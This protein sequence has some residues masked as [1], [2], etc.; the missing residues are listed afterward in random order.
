[1]SRPLHPGKEQVPIV[2]EAGW[3]SWPVWTRAENLPPPGF[4]PRTVE[5]VGSLYTD[6]A[7]PAHRGN[8]VLILKLGARSGERSAS[9]PGLFIL[10]ENSQHLPTRGIGPHSRS[11]RFREQIEKSTT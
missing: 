1:M 5:P 3:V 9:P 8:A 11:R 10:E 6:Y 2:Y 7:L 4:D